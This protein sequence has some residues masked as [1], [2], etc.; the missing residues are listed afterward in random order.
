MQFD[1]EKLKK[2]LNAIID[3]EIK[4]GLV[5]GKAEFA[6]KYKIK[7]QLL[8]YYLT[9]GTFNVY[10]IGRICEEYN[11]TSDYLIYDI[12]PSQQPPPVFL[13]PL[14]LPSTEEE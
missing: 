6:R 4:M 11:L 12:R 3:Y 10:F 1:R 13:P 7:P 8:Q 9:K 14:I 5:R 2:K